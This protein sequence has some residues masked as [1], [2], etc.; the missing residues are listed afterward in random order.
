MDAARI[1]IASHNTLYALIPPSRTIEV[2][3]EG[4]G[5]YY[6]AVPASSLSDQFE[7]GSL[8]VGSQAVGAL[9]HARTAL[10]SGTHDALLHLNR[11]GLLVQQWALP[12]RY[13]HDSV[14][15][16]DG[17]LHSVDTGSGFVFMHRLVAQPTTGLR[18]QLVGKVLAASSRA[19]HI[20][21]V[22]FGGSSQWVLH[23]YT[24][25]AWRARESRLT[26]TAHC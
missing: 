16:A 10:P 24:R 9:P 5:H 12:T 22:A 14:V 3:H 2:L 15:S 6:G 20:N 17:V 8:L 19:E 21:S 25:V 7:C 1:I 11:R 23:P 18:L 4:A 13:L 26:A